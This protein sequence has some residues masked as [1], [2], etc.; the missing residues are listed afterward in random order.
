MW[1]A[2]EDNTYEQASRV[3]ASLLA[4]WNHPFLWGPGVWRFGLS[5][6]EYWGEQNEAK[7]KLLFFYGFKPVEANRRH[8]HHSFLFLRSVEVSIMYSFSKNI[9]VWDCVVERSTMSMTIRVYSASAIYRMYIIHEKEKPN[10]RYTLSL[11]SIISL[12]IF[13]VTYIMIVSL[14]MKRTSVTGSKT[15]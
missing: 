14:D 11:I 9:Y 1:M 10:E 15:N 13:F 12:V 3:H 4:R 6:C 7:L 8:H 2:H 5:A